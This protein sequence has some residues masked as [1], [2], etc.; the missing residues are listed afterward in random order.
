MGEKQS[1]P[2]ILAWVTVNGVA[3]DSKGAT[4]MEVR[5][6]LEGKKSKVWALLSLR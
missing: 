5:Q 6:V 2:L 4:G 3:T 1:H